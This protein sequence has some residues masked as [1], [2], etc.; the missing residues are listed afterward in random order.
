MGGKEGKG[1]KNAILG[2]SHAERNER[3]IHFKLVRK[4]L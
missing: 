2:I 4:K 3:V 1:D